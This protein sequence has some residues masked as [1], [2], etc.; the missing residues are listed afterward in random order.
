MSCC[1]RKGMYSIRYTSM[2]FQFPKD[3]KCSKNHLQPS[4]YMGYLKI[5]CKSSRFISEFNGII[6][7]QPF[8]S[9]MLII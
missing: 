4:V 1:P 7:R 8:P 6:S 5:I 9:S 3:E 2:Y